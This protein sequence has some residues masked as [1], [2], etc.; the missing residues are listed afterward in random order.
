MTLDL[1]NDH[2]VVALSAGILMLTVLLLGLPA[3]LRA[4]RFRRLEH[5]LKTLFWLFFVASD[6][7]RK[8][9]P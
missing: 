6:T 4:V 5:L 2:T 9:K 8:G 1:G 7:A 3:I